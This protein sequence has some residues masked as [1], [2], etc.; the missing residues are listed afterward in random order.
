MKKV[1]LSLLLLFSLNLV[2]AYST[3]PNPITDTIIP[4]Y[5]NQYAEFSL[6]TTGIS[7]DYFQIY[8]LTDVA[9][10]PKGY[11]Y[12]N[13]GQSYN[14]NIYPLSNLKETGYYA[15]TYYLRNQKGESFED[16][17]TVK[18]VQLKNALELTSD[19]IDPNNNKVTF[20]IKNKENINL[21]NIKV[22]FS[23]EVFDPVELTL[24]L[25]A[26]SDTE[27]NIDVDKARMDKVR[28]GSYIINADFATD[29]GIER[30]Q[31]KILLTEKRSIST[32]EQ[33][34]GFLVKQKSIKK[35]NT[36]NVP[37]IAAITMKKD[38]ISRLFTSFNVEPKIVERKALT[39]IYTW[40]QKLQPTQ[41]FEITSKTNYVLPFLTIIFALLIIFGFRKYTKAKLEVKKSISYVKTKG[42]ELALKVTIKIKARKAIQNVSI[43]DKLPGI[44]SIYEKFWTIKP[45]KIDV[46]NKR[47]TWDL[48]NLNAGEERVFSYVVY[49]R[50]GVV[51]KFSLPEALIVFEHEGKLN[52]IESNKVFFLA[53]QIKR[54]DY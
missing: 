32:E 10:S 2:F 38:I 48:G 33:S 45:T 50:I 13:P 7:G 31:G 3:Q 5:T 21:R 36:G 22:T 42:T 29:K 18:I 34:S 41:S 19:Y 51:G 12:L 37:A 9:L 46:I 54:D 30:I 40:N 52:E 4:E 49:S 16:K 20:Y 25:S 44:V 26:L 15:F 24:N 43:I 14:V 47:L 23:S 17:M 53:E 8:T 35:T 1:I 11:F 28:A 6:T 39:V 27:I